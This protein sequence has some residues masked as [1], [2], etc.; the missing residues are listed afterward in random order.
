MQQILAF[1]IPQGPE[2]MIILVV[3]VML[4]G[5]GKLPQVAKQLGSGLRDFKKSL[6]EEDEDVAKS[7]KT[8]SKIEDKSS[9]S[10][11]HTAATSKEVDVV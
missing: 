1:G 2:L 10:P 9:P 11:T 6:N 8:P 7:A 3:V 5:L 4:F